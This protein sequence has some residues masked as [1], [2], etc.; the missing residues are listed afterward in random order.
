MHCAKKKQINIVAND[1]KVTAWN[2][3]AF[4]H[5][6]ESSAEH[7]IFHGC[8][9]AEDELKKKKVLMPTLGLSHDKAKLKRE[10]ECH[11]PKWIS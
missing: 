4:G 3:R 10:N 7:L 1:I 5:T 9:M 8:F 11:R 6:A 2:F